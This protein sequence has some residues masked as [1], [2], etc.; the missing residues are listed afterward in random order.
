MSKI[1]TIPYGMNPFEV[2]FNGDK[3]IYTPGDTVEVPDG[4]AIEIEEYRRTHSKTPD[5]AP[6]PFSNG[7]GGGTNSDV[8]H[9]GAEA[10]TD[11]AA[12][13]VDTDEEAPT[14][15]VLCLDFDFNDGEEQEFGNGTPSTR[16][17]IENQIANGG[18]IAVRVA[19]MGYIGYGIFH[20]SSLDGSRCVFHNYDKSAVLMEWDEPLN[21]YFVTI[22]PSGK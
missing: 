15:T 6:P 20:A 1:V 9:I 19:N 13:W 14:P 7:G 2:I 4:V 10:P 8:V 3:Y 16:T 12:L 22:T 17:M 11:N 18:L 5:P 21:K